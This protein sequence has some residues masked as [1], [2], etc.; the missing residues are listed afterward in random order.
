MSIPSATQGR[1]KKTENSVPGGAPD[2]PALAG[3]TPDAPD[4]EVF[5]ATMLAK[6][7]TR[8]DAFCRE[9]FTPAPALA[10]PSSLRDVGNLPFRVY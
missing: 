3:R 4:L 9:H 7:I 6:M 5:L 2:E 10:G 1:A 8:F